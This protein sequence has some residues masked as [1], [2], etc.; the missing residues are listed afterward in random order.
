MQRL[1]ATL[2]LLLVSLPLSPS[3]ANS[4]RA[5]R[6]PTTLPQRH[7]ELQRAK[8]QLSQSQQH[9]HQNTLKEQ[10]I[11]SQ[12]DRLNRRRARLRQDIH[13]ATQ[14]LQATQS[15]VKSLRQLYT[16]RSHQVQLQRLDLRQRLRQLYKLGR[17]PYAKLL[18]SAND[19]I[20]LS[21]K[22]HYI[23]RLAQHDQQQLH[24]YREAQAQVAST[25]ANLA[26]GE[27]RLQ[28]QQEALH[29]QQATLDHERQQKTALLKQARKEKQLAEQTVTE[30]TETVQ[31]LTGIID[32]L[33]RDQKRKVKRRDEARRAARRNLPRRQTVTHSTAVKGQ[34]LWPVHGP[35]L[36]GF[37]RVRHPSLD[38]YT[39]HK[40]LYIGAP[41]DSPVKAVAAGRV[42]YADW[43]KGLGQLLIID[44]GN[45]LLT[46]YGHTSD[47]SVEI[48]DKVQTHQIVAKVGDSSTLD[49]PAL[50]FAI[51]YNTAPQ[52]PMQWL[53]QQSVSLTHEP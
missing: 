35:V 33:K 47:L 23:R 25:Q 18:L 4:S 36:S 19:V 50:Y 16:Q 29:H 51:R 2:L 22:V 32:Q 17:H 45:H 12:L 30:Y 3:H 10:S 37:G 14:Q 1:W 24:Q 31:A 52:D 8:R 42:V 38:V 9:I 44:H 41:R 26:A 20:G 21:R 43:F 34:L 49:E 27:Q 13:Q 7:Q 40:G 6:Q 39:V 11:L 53:R 28:D 5:L 46:L 48:D 15:Q